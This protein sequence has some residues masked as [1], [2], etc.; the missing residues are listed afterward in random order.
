MTRSS[1]VPK[2]KEGPTQRSANNEI[3]TT[4]KVI[5]HGSYSFRN[6]PT[7]V[8]RMINCLIT[9]VF[10]EASLLV[11]MDWRSK[12]LN[13]IYNPRYIGDTGL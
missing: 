1:V 7:H 13:W 6:L 5:N 3:S 8:H 9:S 2:G 11:T 12:A 4:I 10:Y